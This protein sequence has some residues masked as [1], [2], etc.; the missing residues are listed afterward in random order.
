MLTGFARIERQY[1]WRCKSI[2]IAIDVGI[3][4]TII[5]NDAKR[6]VFCV[7]FPQF[8][9]HSSRFPFSYWDISRSLGA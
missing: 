8:T 1:R 4:L 3:V 9:A 5:G 7:A 6:V 2:E